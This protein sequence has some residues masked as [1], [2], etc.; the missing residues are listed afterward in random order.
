MPRNID[1][2]PPLP[3][4]CN[5][6]GRPR[7]EHFGKGCPRQVETR[8]A[9]AAPVAASEAR[10]AEERAAGREDTAVS[11]EIA[12][13]IAEEYRSLHVN[14]NMGR[15]LWVEKRRVEHGLHPLD[16]QWIWHFEEFYRSDKFLDVGRWGVRAA[17]SDSVCAAL[18]AEVRFMPRKLEPSIV[19][20]CPIMSSTTREAEDRFDTLK[21]NLKSIGLQDVT[22]S[23]TEI[24]LHNFK[25]SGGG[26]APLT[27]ELQDITGHP[28]EFRIYAASET[29]AGCTAIA[30]FG[31]ELDLWGKKGGANPAEKVVEVFVTRFTTVP[32]AKLHLMSATYDRDSYHAQ[33]IR[34]GDTPRQRVARLGPKGAVKDAMDRA[35][36]AR[37]IGSVDPLLL[38][39]ADPMSTDIPC[40]VSNPIAPIEECYRK[41]DG[42]LRRMFAK[43]GGRPEFAGDGAGA[44]AQLD[45]LAERNAQL[46]AIVRGERGSGTLDGDGFQRNLSAPLGDPRNQVV[47]WGGRGGSI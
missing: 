3:D 44:A 36:L 25:T 24:D 20:V 5:L 29:V 14:E 40:W 11:V 9:W 4:P 42:D 8:A 13:R 15:L 1:A 38:A 37:M 19:G 45:G 17:K 35:R 12:D 30:G 46:A 18:V 28:V 39:P 16:P 6:C 26:S 21:A 10:E 33:M 22:G 2:P 32:Q 34:N 23:R 41:M 7:R 43:Y 31:D 47:R 27:I